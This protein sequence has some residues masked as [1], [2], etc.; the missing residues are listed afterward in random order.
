VSVLLPSRIFRRVVC[1]PQLCIFLGLFFILAPALL[2]QEPQD[3]SQPKVMSGL[4]LEDLMNV[5]VETV[6]GASKREQKETTAAASVTIITADD[7]R[8]YGYRTLAELL[9]NVPG[10]YITYDRNYSYAAVQGFGPEGDYNSRILLLIDGH[11]LNDNIY[12]QALLGTEFPLDLDVICRVEIIQG[13][14]SS[15]YG[16]N[17]FFGVINVITRKAGSLKGAEASVTA[18]SLMTGAAN[19]SAGGQT[20]SGIAAFVSASIYSS[21]GNQS[22]F[23]PEFDSPSTSNGYADDA[24]HDRSEQFFSNIS[25]KDFRFQIAYGGRTKQVPTASFGTTFDSTMENTF[26]AHG[27]VDLSYDHVFSSGLAIS[28][29]V[30]L[31]DYDYTGNYPYYL[32]SAANSPVVINHDRSAGDWWG[33]EMKV[34]KTIFR[35]H[36]VTAGTEYRDDF[37]QLQQNYDI[38]PFTSYLDSNPTE[39]EYGIYAQDDFSIRENLL[40]SAGLRH[41]L[42]SDFGGTT[43]PRL[44]LIYN[45]RKR[46]T[47]KFLYGT[48]FRVPNEF[49]LY[50]QTSNLELPNP[51]LQPEKIQSGQIIAEQYLGKSYKFSADFFA[52]KLDHL[53][54]EMAVAPGVLQF[55]NMGTVRTEGVEGTFEAKWSS[56]LAF[57]A[58]Y[59]YEHPVDENTGEIVANIPTEMANANL[60]VPFF[61]KNITAGLNLHYVSS[62]ESLEG[63]PV[64]GFALVNLTLFSEKLEPG[65]QISG[66][67]YNLFNSY[68]GYPGGPEHVQDILYQDGRTFRLKL[69]YTLGRR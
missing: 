16:S 33:T 62:R 55:E 51:L 34:S 57:Q 37:R 63:N 38:S 65:L 26:D 11:R 60:L 3:A 27:Y 40:L 66:S 64:P 25:Y 18:E 14:G 46:T 44:G 2:A 47:L 22:L 59:T 23:F 56:G 61:S 21:R 50:Y 32:S 28:G 31:D 68:Y 6:V 8:R 24:D 43:N 20:K 19:V 53:I 5:K 41:D 36:L 54:D 45:P 9:E 58:N 30:F 48:A 49:E 69:A 17:A 42:G 15:M 13:P 4:S 7:I 35:K 29:R 67:V 1:A 39:Y 10:F 12:D 52:D